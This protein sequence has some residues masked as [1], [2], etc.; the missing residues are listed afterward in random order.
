MGSEAEPTIIVEVFEQVRGGLKTKCNISKLAQCNMDMK[1][2]FKEDC[3]GK[4]AVWRAERC[5]D[6]GNG[7]G[8]TVRKCRAALEN[9]TSST[10]LTNTAF[11]CR[12]MVM[13]KPLN[14]EKDCVKRLERKCAVK[15]TKKQNLLTESLEVHQAAHCW[16]TVSE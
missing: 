1:K 6:F 9:L 8:S 10:V 2:S 5:D 15:V 14:A 7:H 3:A 12:T 11:F 13:G 16:L 4:C